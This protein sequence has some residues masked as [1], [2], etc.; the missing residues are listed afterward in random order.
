VLPELS[1]VLV[2]ADMNDGA[3]TVDIGDIVDP[4]RYA[5]GVDVAAVGI[6][7][8]LTSAF[9]AG[10]ATRTPVVKSATAA[11]DTSIVTLTIATEAGTMAAGS[12]TIVLAYKCL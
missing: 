6:K 5:D 10:L 8:F 4:D 7:E 2:T 3:M 11:A 12:M 1:K 9:A